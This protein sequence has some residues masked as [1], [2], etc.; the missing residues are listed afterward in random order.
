MD[1]IINPWWF[2]LAQVCDTSKII[3]AILGV[4]PLV[5]GAVFWICEYAEMKDSCNNDDCFQYHD[6]KADY[7]RSKK[8]LKL[9]KCMT[10]F[11]AVML[12]IS[13][14]L[15]KEETLIKMQ[16]AKFGTYPNAEKVLEVID[17]KTDALIDAIGSSKED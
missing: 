5:F 9:Y 6:C 2:Y 15:P 4:I 1:Y 16:V 13:I 10:I 12:A 7:N 11:G 3:L 8:Q 17:D 14:L